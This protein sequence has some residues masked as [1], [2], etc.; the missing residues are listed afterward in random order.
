MCFWGAIRMS[1]SV[2]VRAS[3]V[4]TRQKSHALLPVRLAFAFAS[5]ERLE[6]FS[7]RAGSDRSR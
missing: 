4:A 2:L 6:A 7:C 3:S 5:I 1:M